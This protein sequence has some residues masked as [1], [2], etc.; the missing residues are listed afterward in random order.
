MT[1]TPD[2]KSPLSDTLFDIMEEREI[3][4]TD[5]VQRIGF[6]PVQLDSRTL[7]AETAEKLAHFLGSTPNFWITRG[8]SVHTTP[9]NNRRPKK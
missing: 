3:S 1:F 9:N 6:S 8:A 4:E 2:W 7:P 5:F